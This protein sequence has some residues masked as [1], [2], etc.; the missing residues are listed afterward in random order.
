MKT[1]VKPAMKRREWIAAFFRTAL[2]G[3]S[4]FSSAKDSPVIYVM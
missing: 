3:C 1:V 4:S 2:E